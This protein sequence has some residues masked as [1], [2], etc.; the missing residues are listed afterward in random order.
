VRLAR[1]S[2]VGAFVSNSYFVTRS[3]SEVSGPRGTFVSGRPLVD[4]STAQQVVVR[5]EALREYFV[6]SQGLSVADADVEAARVLARVER[7]GRLDLLDEIDAGL[8]QMFGPTAGTRLD[9]PA[10][11]AFYPPPGAADPEDAA[12]R[13]L[14]AGDDVLWRSYL[15]DG[16]VSAFS[17]LS[18]NPSMERFYHPVD[19]ETGVPS[20]A[21]LL[22][23]REHRRVLM[24]RSRTSV[25]FLPDVP[26]RADLTDAAYTAGATYELSVS[27]RFGGGARDCVT[28]SAGVVRFLRRV[29]SFLVADDT[30]DGGL[31]LGGAQPTTTTG[32]PNPPRVVNVTPPAGET[33]IDRTTDWEDPD[34]QFTVPLPAR[35]LFVIR[36]RFSRPLDPRTVDAAHFTLTKTAVFDALGNETPVN[37][38]VSIGPWLSQRR[39]G[40]VLVEITPFANLDPQSRYRLEVLGTVKGLDGTELGETQT[41]DL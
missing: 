5:P 22:R 37:V 16:D 14:V 25:T 15:A 4:P 20:R 24:R 38:P 32:T 27:R 12:L 21:S 41:F 11:N 34:N 2:S 1:P 33:F 10:V 36:V 19:P 40:E 29:A 13:R 7:T 28:E 39:T 3:D 23:Q 8:R 17:T 30:G 35:R 31:F 26:M 6:L 9:D 18:G